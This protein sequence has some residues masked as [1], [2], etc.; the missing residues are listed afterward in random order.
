MRLVA[1]TVLVLPAILDLPAIEIIHLVQEDRL[2]WNF[3]RG[4]E[5]WIAFVHGLILAGQANITGRQAFINAVKKKIKEITIIKIGE[6]IPFQR[7]PFIPAFE[8]LFEAT[9]IVGCQP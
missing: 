9:E 4:Q 7:Q 1:G 8:M 3:C 2:G 6:T 5:T